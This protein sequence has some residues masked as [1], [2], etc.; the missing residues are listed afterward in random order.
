MTQLPPRRDC[1]AGSERTVHGTLG[2]ASN[3]AREKANAR[4]AVGGIELGAEF[5]SQAP[6]LVGSLRELDLTSRAVRCRL[7][8]EVPRF[9]SS[10][11][12]SNTLREGAAFLLLNEHFL[13]CLRV[14]EG[15]D[16]DE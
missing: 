3:A 6:R 9:N 7:L 4:P 2:S 14:A 10:P 1:A 16:Y 13:A 5:H 11:L 12:S 15:G 8:F